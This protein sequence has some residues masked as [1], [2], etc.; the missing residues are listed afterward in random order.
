MKKVLTL[1]LPSMA[2]FNGTAFAG[3]LILGLMHDFRIMTVDPKR[4]ICLSE[5]NVG[6]TTGPVYTEMIKAT[7]NSKSARE[8]MLGSQWNSEQAMKGE[9]IDNVFRDPEDC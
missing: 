3:G 9:V 7:T 5:I 4:A 2:V 6:F 1:G 8:L